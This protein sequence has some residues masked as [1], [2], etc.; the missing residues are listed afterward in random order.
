MYVL[1]FSC[2]YTYMHDICLIQTFFCQGDQGQPGPAGPPGAPGEPGVSGPRGEDG[3]TGPAGF[4]VSINYG[5]VHTTI[6]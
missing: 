5:C 3:D 6:S 1:K 2:A 4:P